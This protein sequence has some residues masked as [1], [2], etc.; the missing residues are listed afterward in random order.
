MPL[1]GAGADAL[2]SDA[3]MHDAMQTY[4]SRFANVPQWSVWTFFAALS[5]QG[6]GLGGIMFD[7]I[8]PNHRQGT[9]IFHDSFIS[10]PP[11]GDPDADAAVARIR[12]WTAVHE[13]GHAFNLAHAWQKSL[14]IGGGGPVGARWSI[15]PR[16]GRS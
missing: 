4:W 8:G 5:D 12:F 10:E 1:G 3:E 2:W 11:P 16:R 13:L 9:A 15:N 14:G 7:D 6:P